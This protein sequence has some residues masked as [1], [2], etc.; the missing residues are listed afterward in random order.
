M[1]EPKEEIT[2]QDV[3]ALKKLVKDFDEWEEANSK[4]AENLK[5]RQRFSGT[6][7]EAHSIIDLWSK[8]GE[9]EKMYWRGAG[10]K[11]PDII[12]G[13]KGIQI[14]TSAGTKLDGEPAVQLL[15]SNH[16]GWKKL[17]SEKNKK[18]VKRRLEK[19][20]QSY[21][22]KR[23]EKTELWIVV[24]ARYKK[25]NYFTLNKRQLSAIVCS[26]EYFSKPHY[27]NRWHY[28]ITKAGNIRHIIKLSKL[29]RYKGLRIK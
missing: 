20:I 19:D 22:D 13:E 12:I 3:D 28:G 27:I 23:M 7:G 24:D 25:P 11:G 9:Q 21:I 2:K 15:T 1:A 8:K 10:K 14:K 16:S 29:H 5:A 6:L 18:M 4:I 26:L 17:R